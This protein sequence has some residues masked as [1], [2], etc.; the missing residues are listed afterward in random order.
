MKLVD[1]LEPLDYVYAFYEG[2]AAAFNRIDEWSDIDL[3]LLVDEGKADDTFGIVE[4]GLSELSRISQKYE[5]SQ[6]PWE[7]VTQAFYKLEN[8][9]DYLLIDLAVIYPS[10][11][12]NFLQPDIHGKVS[13]YFNKRN[14]AKAPLLD[15]KSMR[16][17][18]LRR[19]VT[20]EVRFSMF[21]VFVQKE[22]NRGNWVEALELYR[23]ITL[24]LTVDLLRIMYSPL[25]Y[26]FKTTYV[27]L[28]LPENVNKV[29]ERL[30]FVKNEKDLQI[31]Y[32]EA[33]EW[34]KKLIREKR[35]VSFP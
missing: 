7:G 28:E 9:S 35:G 11:P 2:G 33:T 29:L 4:R 6:L 21:N 32:V 24:G 8:A 25:H 23:V 20:I 15:R 14:K 3:Y 12:E 5:P 27:R 34:F 26:D 13:F 19:L 31:K 17:A 30:Y 16:K 18:I 10:A 1:V 22:I